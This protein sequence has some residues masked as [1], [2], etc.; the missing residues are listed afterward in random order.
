[1]FTLAA[2]QKKRGAKAALARGW[3]PSYSSIYLR[4][5]GTRTVRF[6]AGSDCPPKVLQMARRL[7]DETRGGQLAEERFAELDRFIATAAEAGHELRAYDDALDFVAGR[8]DAIRRSETLD[9]LFPRG[10]ASPVLAKSV[11]VPLYPY[12]AEGALFAV[13][14]G[15]A[16]I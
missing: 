6:R 8:R 16:L 9:R 5:D 4:Y 12:Q 13:R 11:K 14:A 1:E 2:L 15:R 3:R 10:A 7:F